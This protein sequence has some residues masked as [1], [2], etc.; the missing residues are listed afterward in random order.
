MNIGIVLKTLQK[1]MLLKKEKL[2]RQD[3][4]FPQPTVQ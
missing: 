4:S 3:A 2:L 1:F